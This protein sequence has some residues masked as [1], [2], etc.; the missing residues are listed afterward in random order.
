MNKDRNKE[1]HKKSITLRDVMDTDIDIFFNQQLDE[2]A[3]FMAA[4]TAENPADEFAFKDHIK[5]VQLD[6]NVCMKTIV[7]GGRVAGHIA[8]FERLNLPEVSYWLG[9]EFWGKG[10]ATTALE[11]FLGQISIRPMYA[12]VATDNRAS[13]RVL[14]KCGFKIYETN[15]DYANARGKEVEEYVMKL[16][17]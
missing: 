5:K 9:K 15:K 6:Q 1:K 4:F 16:E 17:K 10:I 8:S 14:E 13:I 7:F 12:R 2:E 11:E 3:N